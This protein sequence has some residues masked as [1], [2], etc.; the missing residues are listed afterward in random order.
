VKAA[1][2]IRIG[3]GGWVYPPWRGT[4]YPPRL[5]QAQELQYASRRLTAIE[6][7]GT[8][9]GAQ[10]P[11]SYRRWHDETPEDFVF[12][13]KGPRYATHRRDFAGIGAVFD[14]F[15]SGGVLEL[16]A[17]LGPIL[18]QFPPA[19][20]FEADTIA[21]FLAALPHEAAGPRLR[22]VVE[23]RHRS[24]ANPDFFALLRRHRVALALVEDDNFPRFD[25]ATGDIFY[26]RLRRCAEAEDTGYPA[27]AL[28]AWAAMLRERSAADDR[29]CFLYFINGAKVRAPAAAQALLARLG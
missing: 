21:G 20:R 13:L 15:F 8:F 24:F 25:E 5:P 23:V 6:I 2:K 7:N 9:Y 19:M 11:A 4:F 3:I 1:G 18:W 17:K 26:A 27:S 22:H 16:G 14:R 10:K 12:S 29:D 28:D